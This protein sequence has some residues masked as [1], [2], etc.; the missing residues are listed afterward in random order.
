[1]FVN[2][3][4]KIVACLL[5]NSLSKLKMKTL[6]EQQFVIT[7]VHS[8]VFT[9]LPIY[10]FLLVSIIYLAILSLVSISDRDDLCWIATSVAN[11][12]DSAANAAP[13]LFT[14]ALSKQRF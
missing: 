7:F 14:Q 11:L 13:D 1:M 12:N 9:P 5:N 3:Y 8:L 10:T 4:F 6:F 2:L